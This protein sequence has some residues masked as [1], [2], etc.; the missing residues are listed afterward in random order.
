MFPVIPEP[1]E[2]YTSSLETL[3][4]RSRHFGNLAE[5]IAVSYKDLSDMAEEV[6]AYLPD[7]LKVRFA[8]CG[9]AFNGQFEELS[10]AIQMDCYS[11]ERAVNA[12]AGMLIHVQGEYEKIINDYKDDLI[13]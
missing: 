6:A 3:A 13:K 1:V 9:I 4:T 7:D 12:F 10:E 5:R 8:K 11:H 2:E